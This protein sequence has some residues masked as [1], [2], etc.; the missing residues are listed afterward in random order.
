MI[1]VFMYRWI[2]N[3]REMSEFYILSEQG[4]I[5]VLGSL[6]GY[7]N[8]QGSCKSSLSKL[9]SLHNLST[10]QTFERPT[11]AFTM[12]QILLYF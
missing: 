5:L 12:H 3:V 4:T 2:Q 1:T 10:Y 9:I 6:R 8:S 7:K 11:Y